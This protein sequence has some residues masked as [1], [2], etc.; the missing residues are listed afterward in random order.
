[1]VRFWLLV[2][3]LFG[4][5]CWFLVTLVN[6]FSFKN[7]ISLYFDRTE[8]TLES[9]YYSLVP[10]VCNI[11][12]VFPASKIVQRV[13][14]NGDCDIISEH[15]RQYL[16]SAFWGYSQ[17]R[18]TSSVACFLETGLPY[19]VCT[20]YFLWHSLPREQ[21]LVFELIVDMLCTCTYHLILPPNN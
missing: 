13:Q 20:I 3:M 19:F 2:N 8:E 6:Y 15:S 18:F 7:C 16:Y 14:G 4:A 9:H 1:M 10:F 11:S 12:C 17:S 21:Y 5:K